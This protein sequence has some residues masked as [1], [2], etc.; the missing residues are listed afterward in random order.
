M[1]GTGIIF[2]F[3]ER[4]RTDEKNAV[5]YVFVPITVREISA[6]NKTGHFFATPFMLKG[7][8]VIFTEFLNLQCVIN[9]V[10]VHKSAVFIALP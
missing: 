1:K 6:V 7:S 9:V 10:V 8:Y 2:T 5:L 3:M 4:K